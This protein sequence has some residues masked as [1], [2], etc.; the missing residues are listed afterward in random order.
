MPLLSICIPTLNRVDFLRYSLERLLP[1]AQANGV[2]VCVCDNASVDDTAS[3]LRELAGR[4]ACLRVARAE[5]KRG[6]DANM[7]AV[8]GM[9]TGDHVFPLGDD[10]CLEPGAVAAILAYLKRGD[11]LV[12]LNGWNTDAGLVRKHRHLDDGMAGRTFARP[13]AAFADLWDKMP[14]GSFLARR[15]LFES[16]T[17]G[18]FIGTSHAYTGVV[19]VELARQFESSGRCQVGCMPDPVVLLRGAEKTWKNE[20]VDILLFQIGDWFWKLAQCSP[21]YENAVAVAM[22]GYGRIYLKSSKLMLYKVL[23]KLKG[24]D[25]L[26]LMRIWPRRRHVLLGTL[27]TPVPLQRRYLVRRGIALSE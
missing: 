14:F 4:Y 24:G 2:E 25:F 27:L 19:W 8:I 1:E 26:R 11:D 3:L 5:V 7:L 9:G 20:A 10:D 21:V 12:V 15:H 17:A 16:D 18:Y 22:A 13:D 6:I 23:G